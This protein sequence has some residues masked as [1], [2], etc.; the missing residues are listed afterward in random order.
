MSVVTIAVKGKS[1]KPESM[2]REKTGNKYTNIFLI[3]AG[4]VW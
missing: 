2:H 3:V 1:P 4:L